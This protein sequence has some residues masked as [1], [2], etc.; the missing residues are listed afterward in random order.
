M[1]SP[2]SMTSRSKSHHY[3]RYVEFVLKQLETE[4]KDEAWWVS[5]SIER[6]SKERCRAS[7]GAPDRA[8]WKLRLV[9][10]VGEEEAVKQLAGAVKVRGRWYWRSVGI[11]FENAPADD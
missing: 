4:F 5:A 7:K 11:A 10:R 8:A 9:I 6:M 2:I 1:A 3:A